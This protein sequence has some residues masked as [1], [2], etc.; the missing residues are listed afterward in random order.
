MGARF[1]RFCMDDEHGSTDVF[2]VFYMIDHD[3][4]RG[5]CTGFYMGVVLGSSGV[6][7]M[8]LCGFCT[9]RVSPNGSTVVLYIVL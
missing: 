3:I 2:T 4:L 6:V 8:F 5:L 9:Y 1:T 7:Y